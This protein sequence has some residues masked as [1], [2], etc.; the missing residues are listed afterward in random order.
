[1]RSTG[2]DTI[3]SLNKRFAIRQRTSYSK[4]FKAQVVQECLQPDASVASVALSHSL[5]FLR[6]HA[7]TT[8]TAVVIGPVE[9]VYA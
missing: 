6:P 1:M 8:D 5:S 3:Y 7:C 2:K 9:I 4:P